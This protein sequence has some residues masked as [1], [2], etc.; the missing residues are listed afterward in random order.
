MGKIYIKK[1][2]SSPKTDVE[3]HEKTALELIR[4]DRRW[5]DLRKKERLPVLKLEQV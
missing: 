5:G 2:K 4:G 1:K 3:P